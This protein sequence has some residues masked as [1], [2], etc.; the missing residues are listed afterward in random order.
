MQK[1]KGLK[2]LK[3]QGKGDETR[4]FNY[5]DDFIEG[6]DI[7]ITK[8]KGFGTY[9]IGDKNEISIKNLTKKLMKLLDVKLQIRPDILKKGSTK[10]RKP[11]IKKISKLGYVPKVNLIEGLKD[12]IK[13]YKNN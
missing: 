7:L 8:G 10:R 6:I 4:T 1:K 5:I 3:I 9:N 12:T 13:W 2:I 11:N